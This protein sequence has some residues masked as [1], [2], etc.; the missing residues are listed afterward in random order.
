MR[1]AAIRR[2]FTHLDESA[3]NP[4]IS[5]IRNNCGPHLLVP[6]EKLHA[7]AVLQRHG[8]VAVPFHLV[9]PERTS[10]NAVPVMASIGA[11]V[12][13]GIAWSA[14]AKILRRMRARKSS[15]APSA[16][17]HGG[18][19]GPA[20]PLPTCA[21]TQDRATSRWRDRVTSP[22]HPGGRTSDRVAKQWSDGP[23]PRSASALIT[24]NSRL[25]TSQQQT[26]TSVRR[27]TRLMRGEC[28]CGQKRIGGSV[29]S[30]CLG[31]RVVLSAR[32]RGSG[33]VLRR[34]NMRAS[35]A[36]DPDGVTSHKLA[37]ALLAG[38]LQRFDSGSRSTA[39]LRADPHF[40]AIDAVAV[41]QAGRHV[42]N[43]SDV[44]RRAV[45]TQIRGRVG[46]HTHGLEDLRS[47]AAAA[48]GR[49]IV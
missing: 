36:E 16:A 26:I 7:V 30:E 20:R 11:S 19:G 25:H 28:Q 44:F 14:A 31:L 5:V 12:R 32:E 37:K 15:A 27:A 17:A 33:A 4:R 1:T 10:G 6:G 46:P 2:R 45:R 23:Q 43:R 41:E 8:A 24:E 22:T 3:R 13:R 35:L 47:S 39:W 21:H 29:R 38:V 9:R 18:S 42:W 48:P 40:I 34:R 49:L